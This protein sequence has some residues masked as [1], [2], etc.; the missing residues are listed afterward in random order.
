M[1]ALHLSR[2]NLVV[3]RGKGNKEP[4][5]ECSY[6]NERACNIYKAT[7]LPK[8]A[9][10]LVDEKKHVTKLMLTACVM[11]PIPNAKGTFEQSRE[12]THAF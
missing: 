10:E 6:P 12:G 1:A 5:D 3:P 9:T 11:R 7:T 2:R 8:A 4:L